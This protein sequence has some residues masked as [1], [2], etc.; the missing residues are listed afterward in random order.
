MKSIT[1]IRDEEAEKRALQVI[2]LRDDDFEGSHYYRGDNYPHEEREF[3]AS[4]F[5]HGFDRAVEL[6][7]KRAKVLEE[8][9]KYVVKDREREMK[10]IFE[11][12]DEKKSVI[13]LENFLL[14]NKNT[15]ISVAREALKRYRGKSE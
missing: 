14:D 2:P 7:E 15:H 3:Y 9:L 4:L 11:F 13:W 10:T 1:E 12:L 5:K 8:A 6:M